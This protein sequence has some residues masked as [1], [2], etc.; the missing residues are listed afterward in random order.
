MP[1]LRNPGL[2]SAV[3][4]VSACA[5]VALM[6]VLKA[7]EASKLGAQLVALAVAAFGAR[8]ALESKGKVITSTEARLVTRAK[9]PTWPEIQVPKTVDVELED[10]P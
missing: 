4:F 6:Y 9:T 1:R 10:K 5:L 2:Y 7:P 8:S 3:I